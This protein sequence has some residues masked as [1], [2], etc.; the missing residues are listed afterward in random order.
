M[1]EQVGRGGGETRRAL[2][3]GEQGAVARGEERNNGGQIEKIV[4]REVYF[5][6][7]HDSFAKTTRFNGS[8]E[9]ATTEMLL[10]SPFLLLFPSLSLHHFIILIFLLI[11]TH[12]VRYSWTVQD[13]PR[14]ERVY[15]RMSR[16]LSLSFKVACAS[17]HRNKETIF[18]IYFVKFRIPSIR[19]KSFIFIKSQNFMNS[20]VYR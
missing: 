6:W 20:L 8:P 3:H 14:R 4:S 7:S 16:W 19:V 10:A 12:Y 5:G 17:R 11:Q 15:S 13:V 1:E 18:F 2:K 9:N